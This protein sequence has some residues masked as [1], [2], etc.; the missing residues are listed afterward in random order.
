MFSIVHYSPL[1]SPFLGRS[2]KF[3]ALV[4]LVTRGFEAARAENKFIG[5][6]IQTWSFVEA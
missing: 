2:Y 1:P 3:L 6:G 4:T 5:R